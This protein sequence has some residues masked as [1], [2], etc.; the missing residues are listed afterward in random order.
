[1]FRIL[2]SFDIPARYARDAAVAINKSG[3]TWNKF[4]ETPA[5]PSIVANPQTIIPTYTGDDGL[6]FA[7]AH[8]LNGTAIWTGQ[9]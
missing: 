1:V 8:L 7:K 6:E 2:Y 5:N 3:E 4:G 9:E